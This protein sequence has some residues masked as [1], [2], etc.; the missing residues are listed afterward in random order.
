MEE[1]LQWIR[2]VMGIVSPNIQEQLYGKWQ[3]YGQ[4][5]NDYP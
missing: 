1:L 5:V 2:R 3:S 4:E